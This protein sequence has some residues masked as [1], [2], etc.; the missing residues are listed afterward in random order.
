MRLSTFF[1]LN[2]HF[3]TTKQDNYI[4]GQKK[5]PQYCGPLLDKNLRIDLAFR[6]LYSFN[7]VFS[8]EPDKV[9]SG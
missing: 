8:R 9:D 1:N 7:L 6:H 4:D 3:L 2:H 5:G